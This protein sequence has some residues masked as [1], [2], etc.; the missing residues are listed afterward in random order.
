M[1]EIHPL[2][3]EQTTQLKAD[4]FGAAC[5]R[6]ALQGFHVEECPST[7]EQLEAFE[8]SSAAEKILLVDGYSRLLVG[9]TFQPWSSEWRQ[10][11]KGLIRRMQ[12]LRQQGHVARFIHED[13]LRSWPPLFGRRNH[14]KI[15]L[16]DN[17][18]ISGGVDAN[19]ITATSIDV[20]LHVEDENFADEI[21]RKLH[22][23]AALGVS[24]GHSQIIT[25]DEQT[26][27]VIDSGKRNQSEIYDTACE[28]ANS[29][30]TDSILH[31]TQ[32]IPGGKLAS[33]YQVSPASVT[34]VTNDPRC[35]PTPYRIEQLQLE[36]RT[37]PGSTVDI[38]YVPACEYVHAKVVVF[39]AKDGS[40]TM[41]IGTHNLQGKD[42]AFGTVEAAFITTDQDLIEQTLVVMAKSDQSIAD[43]VY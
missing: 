19:A 3:V 20:S 28:L 21:Y 5:T 40:K 22:L 23:L 27:Y 15:A 31:V 11:R 37:N 32:F 35:L 30:D 26:K 12:H 16:A 38:V 34:I 1:P 42:V 2:D 10:R 9:D 17:H 18:V 43:C 39:T 4:L 29:P 24:Q 36:K 33:I 6:I 25:L 41:I 13:L 8:D 14:V 7:I